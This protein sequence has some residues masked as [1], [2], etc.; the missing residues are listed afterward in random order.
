MNA[1]TGLD[2]QF[3]SETWGGA[4]PVSGS[5]AQ[6]FFHFAPYLKQLIVQVFLGVVL[7]FLSVKKLQ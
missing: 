1:S 3:G 7:L 6:C 4:G 5:N 2:C